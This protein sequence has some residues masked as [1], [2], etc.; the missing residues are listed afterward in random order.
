MTPRGQCVGR[1]LA[2]YSD[3]DAQTASRSSPPDGGKMNARGRLSTGKMWDDQLTTGEED[4]ATDTA[5]K[6][7]GPDNRS[8]G[9]QGGIENRACMQSL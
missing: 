7:L 8:G 3:V 4:G 1:R 9:L 6:A 2:R 5:I